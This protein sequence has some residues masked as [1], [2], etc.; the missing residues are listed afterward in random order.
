VIPIFDNLP[1]IDFD[2]SLLQTRLTTASSITAMNIP[3][4]PVGP[5]SVPGAAPLLHQAAVRPRS[6]VGRGG[7]HPRDIPTAVLH[8]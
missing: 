5:P 6:A 7:D 4:I 3:N 8:P 1:R 2:C